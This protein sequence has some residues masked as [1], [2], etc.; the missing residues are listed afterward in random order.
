M[1]DTELRMD[2]GECLYGGDFG[3]FEVI[4]AKLNTDGN[5]VCIHKYANYPNAK[6]FHYHNANGIN[7]FKNPVGPIVQWRRPNPPPNSN[8]QGT[9]SPAQAGS[10]RQRP[11]SARASSPGEEEVVLTS[12][13]SKSTPELAPGSAVQGASGENLTIH[14]ESAV[15]GDGMTQMSVRFKAKPGVSAR[16]PVLLSS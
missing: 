10:S 4:E 6:S 15:G 14:D 12:P 7:Y 13:S 9:A 3:P 5:L 2:P 16:L 1:S 8:T 11:T